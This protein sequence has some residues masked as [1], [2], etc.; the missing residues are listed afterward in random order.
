MAGVEFITK[1]LT[2]GSG[3]GIAELKVIP[4]K[5][6][7]KLLIASNEQGLNGALGLSYI[8]LRL[9]GF[10]LIQKKTIRENIS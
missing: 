1:N 9:F 3:V 10:P 8:P 6:K 4:K 5:K 7:D 2:N